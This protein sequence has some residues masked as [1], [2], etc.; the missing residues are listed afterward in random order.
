MPICPACGTELESR[1]C[2]ACDKANPSDALYCCY[3]GQ[4]LPDS[5]GPRDKADVNGDPYDLE[6]RVLCSDETCIGIIN[7]HGVCTEC[8]RPRDPSA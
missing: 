2:P 3:C 1:A 8:G 6:A 7:E 4:S 5:P